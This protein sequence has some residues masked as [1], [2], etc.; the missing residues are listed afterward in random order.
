M[1]VDLKHVSLSDYD[2]VVGREEIDEI[3]RLAGFLKGARVQHVNSTA[4]GGGVAEILARLVPLMCDVGIDARW[5]VFQ[6]NPEFYKVTKAFHNA[7]HGTEERITPEMFRTFQDAT[8][9]NLG[10]LAKECDYFAIHDPQPIG[11]VNLRKDTKGKWVWRCHI[12]VADADVVVWGFLRP[13]VDRFDAAIFHLPDYAKELAIPQLLLTPA[14]D[15]LHE[16]NMELP[17]EEIDKTLERY[18]V[19]PRRPVI[20]QVS[21]FDRLK[22]PVGVLQAYRIA[23][24]MV[25][26]QLVLAGGSASDDPEGMQVLAEV[27][28]A[29]GDDPD[30]HILDLPP[31]AHRTINALQR[32]ATVIVQKSLREGFGLVVTEAMWKGKPMIGGAV[33][34]IRRQ[35]IHG[36]TGYLVSSVEGCAFRIRQLLGNPALAKRMGENAHEHVRIN[37]LTPTYLKNWMLTLLALKYGDQPVT[38]LA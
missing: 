27:R 25:D 32:G 5:D 3:R 29:A 35:I 30:V 6:G 1:R 28:A 36:S 7:L 24:R 9:K 4:V 33:G 14:I 13:F 20:L 2:R 38:H 26:C 8:D 22:D 19:D 34:G 31:D 23:R 18:Q 10:L 17:Q 21:R 11:L 16:K 37:Y 12:D 15:P